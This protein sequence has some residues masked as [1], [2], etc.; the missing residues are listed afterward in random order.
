MV[1]KGYDLQCDM[2]KVGE[3]G[4]TDANYTALCC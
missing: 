1:L 4:D 3:W 2:S